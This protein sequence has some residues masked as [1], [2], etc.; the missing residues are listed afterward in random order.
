MHLK[1][2]AVAVA[3]VVF[4]PLQGVAQDICFPDSPPWQPTVVDKQL[5][6]AW[7]RQAPVRRKLAREPGAFPAFALT[8]SG[9]NVPFDGV[10]DAACAQTADNDRDLRTIRAACRVVYKR[11]YCSHW[12][13]PT[14]EFEW[15]GRFIPKS[16]GLETQLTIRGKEQSGS[17]DILMQQGCTSDSDPICVKNLV[18]GNKFY[19]ITYSWPEI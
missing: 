13:I 7:L 16:L 11:E 9:F 18:H 5:Y 15:T 3:A 8:R 2:L 6:S 19:N 12:S 4:L 1:S 14:R 10:C 17:F